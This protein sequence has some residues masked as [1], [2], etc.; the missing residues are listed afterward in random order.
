MAFTP[1]HLSFDCNNRV[2]S[3]LAD[4]AG[5]QSI[6]LS[7]W[8][9]AFWTKPHAEFYPFIVEE[10]A[11]SAVVSELPSDVQ[12]RFPLGREVAIKAAAPA[13]DNQ[14]VFKEETG[15]RLPT[16]FYKSKSSAAKLGFIK[17]DADVNYHTVELEDVR[18]VNPIGESILD[19]IALDVG[20]NGIIHQRGDFPS[21]GNFN[22]ARRWKVF[23]GSFAYSETFRL[24]TPGEEFPHSETVFTMESNLGDVDPAEIMLDDYLNLKYAE[25][26][27]H[28]HYEGPGSLYDRGL[29]MSMGKS[30]VLRVE[31]TIPTAEHYIKVGVTGIGEATF[32]VEQMLRSK[33][34]WIMKPL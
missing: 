12:W 2:W 24:R 26:I 6:P 9:T 28:I 1:T 34:D 11:K 31:N 5:Y 15:F 32:R 21:T 16:F 3:C 10:F 30:C 14:P 33:E 8:N 29:G 22:D 27:L 7:V 13:V 17:L 25:E 19:G 4:N 18:I 23:D 20:A